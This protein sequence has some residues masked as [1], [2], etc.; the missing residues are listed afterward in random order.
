MAT[1]KK[2]KAFK[3]YAAV[4]NVKTVLTVREGPGIKFPGAIIGGKKLQLPPNMVISICEE[5]SG[6]GRIADTP[7]WVSLAY[8]KK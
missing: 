5:Q 4:V 3:T 2:E 1:A 6:F 8:L 7:Y